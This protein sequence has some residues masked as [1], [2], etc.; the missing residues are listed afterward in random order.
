MYGAISNCSFV[1]VPTI[2]IVCAGKS[3]YS[4]MPASF[5]AVAKISASICSLTTTGKSPLLSALLRKMSAKKLD[6]TARNPAPSMAHAACSRLEPQPK[7]FPATIISPLYTGEFITKPALGLPSLSYRQS[8]NRFSPNPSR[9]V[10]FRNRA[11]IIWSVSMFSIGSGT[12][13]ERSV[14]NF[15]LMTLAVSWFYIIVRGSVIT[16]VTAAAAATKGPAN[17]VRASGP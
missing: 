1:S 7:F 3:I 14:V 2:S 12:T 6:T 10:A 13:V 15:C 4:C 9:V 8:R 11:G 17:S 16:P 5:S